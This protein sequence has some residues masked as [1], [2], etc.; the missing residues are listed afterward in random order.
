MRV[1]PD[2]VVFEQVHAFT[3][4]SESLNFCLSNNTICLV[5]VRENKV[6]YA[7]LFAR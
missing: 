3:H 4:G 5:R 2:T 6:S 7:A 1:S